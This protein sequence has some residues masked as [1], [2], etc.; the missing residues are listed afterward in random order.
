MAID[1]QSARP[2]RH[3]F[4]PGEV[5]GWA[6]LLGPPNAE[7]RRSFGITDATLRLSIGIEDA[8]DLI[9]DLEQALA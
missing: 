8:P 7:E 2:P 9:A 5:A 1:I 6:D 4:P 3:P